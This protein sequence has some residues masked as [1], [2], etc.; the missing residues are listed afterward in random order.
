[1]IQHW[2]SHWLG[3]DNASG[4]VYLWWSGLFGDVTI[5]SI[6]IVL[7]RKH[8][9]NIHKC[10]RLGRHAVEGTTFKV[11]RA[12]HPDGHLTHAHLLNLHRQHQERRDL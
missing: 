9:C 6:P 2:L 1:M 3:L 8:N 10:W 11:C 7:L 4:S 12:H 5:L